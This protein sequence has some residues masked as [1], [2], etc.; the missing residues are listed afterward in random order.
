MTAQCWRQTKTHPTGHYHQIPGPSQ[1]WQLSNISNI[2]R[3]SVL[4]KQK[5]WKPS[6]KG[7][8]HW[9]SKSTSSPLERKFEHSMPPFVLMFFCFKKLAKRLPSAKRILP[10]KTKFCA[11][12]SEASF[13]FYLANPTLHKRPR[14][15]HPWPG[16]GILS[17]WQHNAGDK[18][19][20][21]LQAIIIRFLVPARNDNLATCAIS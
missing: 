3:P 11:L 20:H 5:G 15:R 6:T 10:N 17:Q 2:I 14:H 19:K 7:A 4:H 9:K 1:E 8:Q 21:I 13:T 16:P 12:P 18:P